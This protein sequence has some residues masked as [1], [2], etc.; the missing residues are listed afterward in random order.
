MKRAREEGSGGGQMCRD[1]EKGICFRGDRC[2]FSHPSKQETG[3]MK[4]AF[5]TDFRQGTCKFRECI[6]VHSPPVLEEEYKR[7]GGRLLQ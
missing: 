5:C 6:Y 2:K 1:F 4:I 3:E 7:T